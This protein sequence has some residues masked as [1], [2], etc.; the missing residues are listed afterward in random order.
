M[1]LPTWFDSACTN[2]SRMVLLQAVPDE[3]IHTGGR[4][5]SGNGA[6]G[7]SGSTLQQAANTGDAS[8]AGPPGHTLDACHLN[9]TAAAKASLQGSSL[10]DTSLGLCSHQFGAGILASCSALASLQQAKVWFFSA[11]NC[12]YLPH[13]RFCSPLVCQSAC[14]GARLGLMW[15]IL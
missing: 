9:T 14:M 6:G 3:A 4:P 1:A 15:L 2:H 7:G 11:T 8:S 12:H 10:H 5:E 13:R